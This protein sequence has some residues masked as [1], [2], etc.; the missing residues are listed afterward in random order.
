MC[1]ACASPAGAHPAGRPAGAEAILGP[2]CARGGIGRRARLRALWGVFPVVVRVHSSAY[3][4]SCKSGLSGVKGGLDWGARRLF[5]FVPMARP[6]NLPNILRAGCSASGSMTYTAE[7]RSD[8]VEPNKMCQT[9]CHRQRGHRRCACPSSE[10]LGIGKRQPLAR[11]NC[12]A[13]HVRAPVRSV[14]P[15]GQSRC[16]RI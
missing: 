7:N 10:R 8:P 2:R 15:R 9:L 12:S 11:L 13:W 5:G 16:P 1:G 6:N 4:K 3:E 14:R